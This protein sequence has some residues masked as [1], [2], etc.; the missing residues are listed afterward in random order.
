MATTLPPYSLIRA[1]TPPEL[2]KIFL[3]ATSL[4]ANAVS[5]H[6]LSGVVQGSISPSAFRV[7]LGVSRSPIAIK[8]ALQQD[9]S[10]AVRDAGIKQFGKN[11]KSARWKE[12]WD[13]LGGVEGL[14]EFFSDL[15]IFEI[16]GVRRT[17]IRSVKGSGRA[18][19]AD[20]VFQLLNSLLPGFFDGQAGSQNPDKRPLTEVYKGL[21]RMCPPKVV[22]RLLRN[23]DGGLNDLFLLENMAQKQVDVLR[24][25]VLRAIFDKETTWNIQ[26]D[27]SLLIGFLQKWPS[28]AGHEPNL[29]ASMQFSLDLLRRL[30]SSERSLFP[31]EL[32]IKELVEPL[33]RRCR[34]RKADWTQVL[35]IVKLTAD[36]LS[37]YPK[38]AVHLSFSSDRLIQWVTQSWSRHPTEF[39][40]P[41]KDLIRHTGKD[42]GLS[43]F[44]FSRIKT[45]QRYPLLRLG[46]LATG[47]GNLD[48]DHDLKRMDLVWSFRTFELLETE[49]AWTLYK[50]LRTQKETFLQSGSQP[51]QNLSE[52]PHHGD[53]DVLLSSLLQRRGDEAETVELGTRRTF[54]D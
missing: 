3:H 43:S 18:E 24:P 21:V 5:E 42:V 8:V 26:D 9:Q 7:W 12:T 6:L 22:E 36:Y 47:Q 51:W 19:K 46:F 34:R 27:P 17:I 41:L 28:A 11:L 52:T 40:G 2:A 4:S 13:K 44:R 32:F 31:D 1:S 35:E 33:V 50:R 53:P 10:V 14:L 15:S 29:S 16:K 54:H 39:E 20:R 48:N 23:A 45:K 30:A 37:R 38:A 49:H 25:F